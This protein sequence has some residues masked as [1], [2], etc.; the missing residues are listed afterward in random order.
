MHPLQ[1]LW[2]LIEGTHGAKDENRSKCLHKKIEIVTKHIAPG[3]F[4]L[5]SQCIDCKKD[6]GMDGIESRLKQS[7]PHPEVK[8]TKEEI[9]PGLF[10]LEAICPFCKA[11]LDPF[12]LLI[13]KVEKLGSENA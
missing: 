3:Y 6:M 10:L 13:K 8:N 7:C 9:L 2:E 11:E 12:Q 1:E 5:T 4:K